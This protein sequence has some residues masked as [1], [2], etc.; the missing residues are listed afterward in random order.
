[1]TKAGDVNYNRKTKEDEKKELEALADGLK[2]SF[3]VETTNQIK[4]I[5]ENTT[6]K[7]GQAFNVI[8]YVGYLRTGLKAWNKSKKI[9]DLKLAE[10][11]VWLSNNVLS[12]TIPKLIKYSEIYPPV[13]SFLK[14]KKNIISEG[15]TN[16]PT[17][18]FDKYKPEEREKFTTKFQAS[19]KDWSDFIA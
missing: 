16:M 8:E 9:S 19:K 5:L 14:S 6:T 2:D 4:E 13:K 3:G 15:F 17:D 7:L 12:N 11:L 10:N 18:I 1:M